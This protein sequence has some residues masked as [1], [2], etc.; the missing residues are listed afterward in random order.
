MFFVSLDPDVFLADHVRNNMTT[1][2]HHMSKCSIQEE[3]FGPHNLFHNK[4]VLFHL[5][6]HLTA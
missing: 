6:I 3:V 4:A 5:I 2:L 1:P